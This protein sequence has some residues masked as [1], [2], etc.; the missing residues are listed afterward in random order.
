M[1]LFPNLSETSGCECTGPPAGIDSRASFRAPGGSDVGR[2]PLPVHLACSI[3]RPCCVL[4]AT[5]A[6]A[7]DDSPWRRRGGDGPGSGA[8][9]ASLGKSD[10]TL[11]TLH[12]VLGSIFAICIFCASA[13]AELPTEPSAR[14]NE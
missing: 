13:A 6:L 10:V 2:T 14:M 12:I 4:R 3:H 7:A 8:G 5:C 9:R 11:M 1:Y